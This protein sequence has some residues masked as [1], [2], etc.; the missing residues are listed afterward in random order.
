MRV[1]FMKL[2]KSA[3]VAFSLVLSLG[4]FSTTAV[5]CEAGRTCFGPMQGIDMV[6]GHI[7]MAIKAVDEGQNGPSV[8]EHVNA[9][10]KASKEINAN[11]KVDVARSRAN[12]HLKKA[13]AA[14]KKSQMQDGEDHLGMA[15]KAFEGLKDL[16]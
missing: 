16:L 7:G 4:S 1:T 12:A 3:I 6:L 13:K 15:E 8:N 14:F 11:D 5:A 9:A 10:L 2:L